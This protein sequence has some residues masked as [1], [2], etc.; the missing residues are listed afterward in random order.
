[1]LRLRE[2][3]LQL[4]Y[5]L[6]RWGLESVLREGLPPDEPEAL[7]LVAGTVWRLEA[8]LTPGR[9]ALMF[10]EVRRVFRVSQRTAESAVREAYDLTMQ[11]RLETLLLPRL[12][13]ETVGQWV[14]VLGTTPAPAL[15]LT[16][17][18]GNLLLLGVALGLALR[19]R[20]PAVELVLFR[21]RGVAPRSRRAIGAVRDTY[22]NRQLA[23]RRMRE[24]DSLPVRWESDASAVAGHLRAGR[25]VL[26]AFDDRAWPTYE[27]IPFFEREALLSPDPWRIAEAG[28]FPVV[29]ASIRREPDKAHVVRLGAAMVP[30]RAV[31]LAE[32]AV[33]FLSE[34]PGH[35][36]MWLAECRMRAAMDDHPLFVDYAADTRWMRWPEG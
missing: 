28:G 23:A 25:V 34:N 19:R 16:P 2:P 3:S 12:A 36:A 6:A 21:A 15:V 29:P 24:E 26:A 32:E 1:V 11:A 4:P 8:Q 5:D 17:H 31:Y 9:A 33:P 35:Y 18:A 14:R 7:R 27:R 20:E 22:V 13:P 10:D 30:D